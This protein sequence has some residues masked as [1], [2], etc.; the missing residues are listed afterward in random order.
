MRIFALELNNDI[1]GLENRKMYIEA[2]ISKL[3]SPDLVLLPELATCSYIPN[4]SIWHYAD[5][6]SKDTS[7]WAKSIAGKYNTYIGVGYIDYENNNYYNRYLIADEKQIYGIVT[8][9]EAESAI[10]KRGL[11]DNVIKTPFG[12]V[13]IAICYDSKRKFFYNNIKDE[14]ISLIVFPHGSF[15]SFKKDSKEEETNDYFCNLYVNA[16]NV[17]VIYVNSYG[18]LEYMPGIMG[19]LMRINKFKMNGKTKIYGMNGEK[20]ILNINEAKGYDVNLNDKERKN[21]I[22]FYGNNL[23]KGN[24]LFRHIIL[25]PDVLLGIKYYNKSIK[26][27]INKYYKT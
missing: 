23:L 2:L 26:S 27:K 5:N 18:K 20:I 7:T 19:F 22:L 6:G 13:A 16:F 17:P 11:F 9:S 4:R 12:N 25:K 21:N 24:F 15:A 10:F 8:K 3:P 1:K 14:K